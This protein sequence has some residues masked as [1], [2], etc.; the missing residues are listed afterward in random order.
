MR[1]DERL[2]VVHHGGGRMVGAA[3][4]VGGRGVMWNLRAGCWDPIPSLKETS[5]RDCGRAVSGQH[6][7]VNGQAWGW[8]R[9][10][11]GRAVFGESLGGCHEADH[12]CTA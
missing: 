11:G 4:W 12:V 10:R 3:V 7:T 9:W 5:D 8:G 2:K 1:E 6:N